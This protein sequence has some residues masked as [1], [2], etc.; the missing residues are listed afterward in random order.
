MGRYFRAMRGPAGA[1]LLIAAGLLA[2]GTLM[3]QRDDRSQQ[4]WAIIALHP[5]AGGLADLLTAELSQSPDVTLVERD[6]IRR[7]LDELNLQASGLVS[8]GEATRFGHLSKA[9]GLVLLGSDSQQKSQPLRVRLI[10]TRSSVRLLDRVVADASLDDQVDIIR[11]A[12]LAAAAPLSVSEKQLRFI[13]VMPVLSAEPGNPMH[14]E[15]DM[16]TTLLSAEFFRLPEFVVLEREDLERLTAERDVSGI[17]LKW[18]GATRMLELGLRRNEANTGWIASC[19]LA[20]PGNGNPQLVEVRCETKNIAELRSKIVAEVLNHVGGEGVAYDADSAEQEAARFDRQVQLFRSASARDREMDAYKMAE[21]AYALAANRKRFDAVMRHIVDAIEEHANEKQWLSALRLGVRHQELKLADLQKNG[22]SLIRMMTRMPPEEVRKRMPAPKG[23]VGVSHYSPS[24]RATN[25]QEQALLNEILILRRN[26]VDLKLRRAKDHPLPTFIC[27]LQKYDLELNHELPDADCVREISE[28]MP[29]V[30]RSADEA[31]IKRE[32]SDPYYRLLF[33]KMI[34]TLSKLE[35]VRT[36]RST[37]P[38]W[39]R[40][41]PQLWLD[42]LARLD[43][44]LSRL[45]NLRMQLHERGDAGLQAATKLLAEIKTFPL[46]P[47]ADDTYVDVRLRTPAFYRLPPQQRHEYL[48]D[49][50]VACESQQDPSQLILHANSFRMY[51]QRLPEQEM[52][53]IGARIVALLNLEHPTNNPRSRSRAYLLGIASRYAAIDR[54]RDQLR[55]RR[56]GAD[57][58]LETAPGAWQQYVARTLRPKPTGKA[59]AIK[60]VHYDNRK[61]AVSRGG[62]LILCWGL[63]WKGMQLER[64]NLATGKQTPIGKEFKGAPVAFRGVQVCVSPNA[65]FVAS[66]PP[67]FTM[68]TEA[69]TRTFTK[70]DGLVEEDIW[71]MAWWEDRLYIGYKDAF[72]MFDPETFEFQLLASSLSVEPKNPIDGRGGFFVRQLLTDRAAGCIW[73]TVQDNA[74]AD[75]TGLWRVNPQTNTFHR[76]SDRSTQLTAAP[77]GLLVHNNRAPYL[78]WLPTGTT[79]PIEL[80]QFS[81]AS[82]KTPGPSPKLIRVGE[83]VISERGGLFTADGTSHQAAVKDHWSLLQFAGDGIVTHY[84]HLRRTLHL[85]ERKK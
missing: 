18:R 85:I 43:A 7:V 83:H 74:N 72:G 81:H 59:Y 70:E 12:L 57:F 44:P 30:Y 61:D 65:I 27:L 8:R 10:D 71:S 22:S 2:T 11:Q 47:T 68:V 38:N 48:L 50:L 46:D 55:A 40:S 31:G 66:D 6:Q 76:L 58:T 36:S 35:R 21:A 34:S 24:L 82:A 9:M 60:H 25:A 51:L 64:L 1:M 84:D 17:E 80:P 13:S 45:A 75:R 19:R 52:R 29:S 32:M 41:D 73:M 23:F 67:G 53:P 28:L 56:N 79:T 3:A 14:A 77:G 54:G 4:Q 16:L 78:A 39:K 37:T 26:Y 20:T 63:P 5:D 49:V 15:C 69:F 42:Q 62:E 33:G